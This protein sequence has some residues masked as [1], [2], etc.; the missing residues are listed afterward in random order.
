MNKYQKLEN[1]INTA[2]ERAEPSLEELKRLLSQVQDEA[3]KLKNSDPDIVESRP[4]LYTLRKSLETE[5]TKLET[6]D[7][8]KRSSEKKVGSEAPKVSVNNSDHTPEAEN[9]MKQA[10][11]LFYKGEYRDSI[12]IYERVLKLE[13]NWERAKD[14]LAEAENH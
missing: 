2:L 3:L 9:L 13:P 4:Y 1:E 11:D 12:P 14:H 5:I 10:E 6:E 7:K 8:S